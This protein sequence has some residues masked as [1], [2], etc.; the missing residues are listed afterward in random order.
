[1][2]FPALTDGAIVFRSCGPEQCEAVIE[3]IDATSNLI[4]I[5][6]SFIALRATAILDRCGSRPT[7]LHGG[8]YEAAP[9]LFVVR[10]AQFHN[11]KKRCR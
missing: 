3:I 7:P 9:P 1:M 2:F 6:G 5:A 4:R 11:S 10:E 8:N